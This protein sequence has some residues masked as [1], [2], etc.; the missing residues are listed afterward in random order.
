MGLRAFVFFFLIRSPDGARSC[1]F[2]VKVPMTR[3]L[4][5]I[6]TTC[7]RWNLDSN[8]AEASLATA[9]VPYGELAT[10]LLLRTAGPLPIVWDTYRMG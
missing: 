5:S 8:T 1:S 10:R 7:P 9:F 2:I 4:Y 6:A 3:I